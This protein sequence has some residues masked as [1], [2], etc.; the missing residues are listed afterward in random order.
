MQLQPNEKQETERLTLDSKQQALQNSVIRNFF[1]AEGTLKHLPAQYKKKL[2][3]LHHLVSLL[4]PVR[5]YAEKEINEFIKQFH[6]DYATIRREFIIHRLMSR[7]QEVYEV[8]PRDQW[9]RWDD[10]N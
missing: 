10:L 4:D 2:I 7:D 9:E 5:K 3:V 8:N 1:T 6:G